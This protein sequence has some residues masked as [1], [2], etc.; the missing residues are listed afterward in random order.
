MTVHR[1]VQRWEIES[2]ICYI[3]HQ[4][5]RK[6]T[7]KTKIEEKRLQLS[8]G[9]ERNLQVMKQYTALMMIGEQKL[10]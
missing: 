5:L 1:V 2:L 8:F 4:K 9:G 10:R 3:K 7:A 6:L